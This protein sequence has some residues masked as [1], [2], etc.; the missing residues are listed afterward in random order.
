MTRIMRRIAPVLLTVIV[1]C[2]ACGTAVADRNLRCGSRIISIGD[3]MF[4]VLAACGEPEHRKKWEEHLPG[5][6][7]RFYDYKT[8]RYRLPEMLHSPLRM[9]LWTYNLG[10]N[11]FIR[12]LE[13]ENDILIR[14]TT[15]DKGHD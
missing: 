5:Y 13:F 12:Y 14:I 15:G 6:V 4:E 1:I 10:S 7:F 11:R 2:C 9:E 3:H 8:E